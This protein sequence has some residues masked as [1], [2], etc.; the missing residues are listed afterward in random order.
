MTFIDGDKCPNGIMRCST[1]H[2]YCG[3]SFGVTSV[4]EPSKCF[5]DVQFSVLCWSFEFQRSRKSILIKSLDHWILTQALTG[6][7]LTFCSISRIL[8]FSLQAYIN[9]INKSYFKDL[10]SCK[11]NC[12]SL[13]SECNFLHCGVFITYRN[14]A[15][16]PNEL[17]FEVFLDQ[18][19]CFSFEASD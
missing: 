5:Y 18:F 19:G 14:H 17:S 2:F 8:F 7:F 10:I 12:C 11:T 15:M 1:V 4:T 9:I 6:V 16:R 13:W 3:L